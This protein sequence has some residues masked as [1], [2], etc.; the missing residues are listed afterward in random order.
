MYILCSSDLLFFCLLACGVL[1]VYYCNKSEVWCSYLPPTYKQGTQIVHDCN[2]FI[3]DILDI[4][5][6]HTILITTIH[7][8][9]VHIS[10]K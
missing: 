2:L 8:Y 10:I 5:Q 9:I 4:Q 1:H 6:F 3:T 7:F